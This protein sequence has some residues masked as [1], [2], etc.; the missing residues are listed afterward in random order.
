MSIP[1]AL[2]RLLD[3]VLLGLPH[4]SAARVRITVSE[5]IRILG[6]QQRLRRAIR[7]LL[8]NA[9]KYSPPGSRLNISATAIHP[10][11]QIG[12]LARSARGDGAG[13]HRPDDLPRPEFAIQPGLG[14]QQQQPARVGA[15]LCDDRQISDRHHVRSHARLSSRL[16]ATISISRSR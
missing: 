15:L 12:F 14:L 3:D 1:H 7:S 4:G 16:T 10:K 6:D 9:L 8:D 5:P 2:D 13:W 11:R